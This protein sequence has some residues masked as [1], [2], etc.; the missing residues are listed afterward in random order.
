[1]LIGAC[2]P[3]PWPIHVYRAWAGSISCHTKC[4]PP[5]W[6]NA[7]M[8]RHAETS[9]TPRTKYTSTETVAIG[10]KTGF[11]TDPAFNARQLTC[12]LGGVWSGTLVCVPVI[13]FPVAT[14][15]SFRTPVVAPGTGSTWTPQAGGVPLENTAGPAVNNGPTATNVDTELTFDVAYTDASN[16]GLI[17]VAVIAPASNELTIAGEWL[18]GDGSNA[19][20]IAA[21]LD[22]SATFSVSGGSGVY[23]WTAD[24]IEDLGLSLVYTGTDS[25]PSCQVRLVG[26]LEGLE[27]GEDVTIAIT[28]VDR[29]RGV[30]ETVYANVDIVSDHV[31]SVPNSRRLR[32]STW[33]PRIC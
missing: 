19:Q 27:A 28:A 18:A 29:L 6:Q 22:L 14:G 26:N 3:M 7:G 25:C 31:L 5:T 10:C 8:D 33:C 24:P 16:S 4:A 32:C 11:R 13:T 2:N 30:R 9:G 20:R 17:A 12:E 21:S 15:G 1:M 23:D